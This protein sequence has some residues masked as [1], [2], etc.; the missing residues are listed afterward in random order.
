HDICSFYLEPHDRHPLPVF[1]PGQYLTFRLNIPGQSKPVIRCYSLSDAPR[2]DHFR[3]TIKRIGA[4]PGKPDGRPGLVSSHFHDQT[5]EG[6]I[7]DVKA[8]AGQFHLDPAEDTPVVLI[9]GGI[10]LTPVLSML[11]ALVDAH[12]QRNIW[13]FYGLRHRSEHI[14]AEHLRQI[15]EDNPNIQVHICYSDPRPN[16]DRAGEHYDHAE[17]VSID[18]LKRIVPGE[19]AHFYLCGPPPMMQSLVEGFH[20]WGVDDNRIHYEAFGPAS[21][22]GA[23]SAH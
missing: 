9:G 14:M 18:L 15:A 10:G 3:V 17:R 23:A 8:P 13:F 20:G 1:L 16:E 21:I 5:D 4:P 12:T 2:T 11:N 22:K 7:V 19:S 6:D